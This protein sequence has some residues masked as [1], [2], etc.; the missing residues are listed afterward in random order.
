MKKIKRFTVLILVIALSILTAC[1]SDGEYLL[2]VTLEGGS[3][4]AHVESPVK[5]VVTDGIPSVTI[6]WS[7]SNYDYMIVNDV[8][9]M[10]ESE[11]DKP[12]SFTFP[13]VDLNCDMNVIG[14]TTAMSTPHEIEYVLHFSEAQ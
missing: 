6:V 8:K 3:G 11:A 4:K 2:E 7:S 14:D 10:N 9:Y 5:A 12:S 1:R 13:I